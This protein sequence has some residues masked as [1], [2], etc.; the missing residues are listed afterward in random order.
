MSILNTD[1]TLGIIILIIENA[2]L[3]APYYHTIYSNVNE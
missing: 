2:K 1:L 3:N